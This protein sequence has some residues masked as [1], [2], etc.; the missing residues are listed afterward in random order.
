MRP[1]SIIRWLSTSLL[2]SAVVAFVLFGLGPHSGA[3]RTLTILSDSMEPTFSAGDAIIA[4]PVP[5]REVR[6][7]D[8]ITYHAPVA[9]RPVVTHRVVKVTEP[10]DRPV[11]LTQGDANEAVDPWSARLD[12]GTVWRHSATIPFA[13]HAIRALRHDAVRP[14]ATYALPLLV[15]LMLLVAIWRPSAPTRIDGDATDEL[16]DGSYDAVEP[17]SYV[18]VPAWWANEELVEEPYR[19]QYPAERERFEAPA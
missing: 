12:G 18:T 14:V 11:I 2:T 4:T 3:Y 9:G 16:L 10:G 1:T 5:S 19:D 17:R 7:G 15:V 13:G 8:V 6:A